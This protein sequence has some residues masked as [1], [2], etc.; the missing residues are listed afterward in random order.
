MKVD[1][2]WFNTN[3]EAFFCDSL[4]AQ[5][6]QLASEH[7]KTCLSCRSEVQALRD[8]DPLVKQL[9]EFRMT[10][11]I[12][13]AHAP[14]RSIGFQT[15]TGRRCGG[16]GRHTGVRGL[17]A[18]YAMDPAVVLQP[19][20]RQLKVRTLRTAAMR[21]SMVLL[22]IRGQSQMLPT[23]NRRELS[24]VRSRPSRTTRRHFW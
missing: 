8:V 1:C 5:Q 18:S 19:A 13:G 23:R 12:A 3:L 4:D 21:R 16:A 24:L 15:W 9:L 7:L 11:A 22:Q 10:K 20:K 17:P 2:Q 14:R 6:L